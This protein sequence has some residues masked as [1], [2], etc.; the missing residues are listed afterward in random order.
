MSAATDGMEEIVREFLAESAEGLDRLERDLVELEHDPTS[1]PRLAEIFRAVH[2]LKGS[3][4]MLGYPK[5][6]LVAHAGESLLGGLRDG[7]LALN[8]ALAGGLLAMVD[9]LRAL[10][11]AIERT[12]SEGIDD[13]GGVVRSLEELLHSPAVQ[14]AAADA[15]HDGAANGLGSENT[16]SGSTIRVDV[17]LL[18]RLMDLAG[19]LVL[20]R[21][22]TL[23]LAASQA[24]GA[25][26]SAAQRLKRVT[27]DLQDAV[28]K[29]RLQPIGSIWNKF[30]RLARDLALACGKR[31]IVEMEG[32]ETELDRA[33]LEAIKDP[34]IHILRNAI[35]HGIETPEQRT[36]AGKTAA[37]HLR[38]R[39]FHLEGRV[40]VE[41]SDDGAGI[42]LDRVRRRA[43]ERGLITPE[44][45][46]GLSEQQ[47]ARLAFVPGFSTAETVTNVS[48]RG[49]GLDVVRTNVE[50]M[51]G[52][53][54]LQSVTG[55]GVA[56]HIIIP[57]TLA[58]LPV[59]IV[60][61]GGQR[62][63]I[64]QANLIAVARLE[65]GMGASSIERVCGAPVFRLRDGLLPLCFLDQELYLKSSCADGLHIV[66]LQASAGQ[67]GLVVDAVHDTEEIV[68]KPL[69]PQLKGLVC[70]AGAA[71]LGDGQV[72]LILDVA[73][74]AQRAG[75]VAGPRVPPTSEAAEAKETSDE[76][77]GN[78]LVFRGTTGSRLA[79]PL[80]AVAR[81]EEIPAEH[82]ERSAGQ[83]VVQYCGE[84]LPLLRVSKL[85]HEPEQEGGLLQVAVL[86]E[87]GV[88]VGLVMDR[89]EDIVEAVVD[90]RR[91]GLSDLV[92][93][94]AVIQDRV[95]DVLNLKNV[96]AR[97]R[98]AC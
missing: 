28:I 72:V 16:T 75:V 86:R 6:E 88:G 56:L 18:D 74:L 19:E 58:I 78:W 87:S 91:D 57:L 95:A 90:L 40:H 24:D 25:M 52:A 21:N 34:L 69:G 73:G 8:P 43:L 10:L 47:L 42:D 2:T 80:S 37:G 41:V 17:S 23:R 92:E 77:T 93:G 89:I 20:A 30:P 12:G 39:S 96:L 32:A 66:V 82:I 15:V 46:G 94:T 76:A 64:P 4:G 61:S 81:L 33:L 31:V 14:V 22:Q 48:G 60:S 44:Q 9:A 1:R 45:A 53:V 3:S 62:F 65:R 13:Y 71:I 59:I 38:F 97:G 36:R 67:F 7:K 55:E 68:V 50:K 26:L 83:E 27:S 63:A 29:A 35:A 79:L 51:G 54:D 11:G 49:V 70:F 5:L 98:R 85:F 84:I